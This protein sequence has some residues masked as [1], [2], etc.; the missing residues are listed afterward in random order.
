MQ[1][2]LQDAAVA[3]AGEAM[4]AATKAVAAVA[5]VEVVEEDAVILTTQLS[6]EERDRIRKERDKKGEPGGSNGS[7]RSIS[8]MTTKQLT[9]ATTSSI[10]VAGNDSGNSDK[11]KAETPKKSNNARNSFGGRESAKRSKND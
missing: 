7:K 4:V 6:F 2:T 5:V 10:K 9:S 3:V 11:E 1:Q 8:E